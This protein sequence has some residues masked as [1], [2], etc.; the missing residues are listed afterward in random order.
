VPH[1]ERNLDRVS[2]THPARITTKEVMRRPLF[3]CKSEVKSAFLGYRLGH[4]RFPRQ[5]L[6][7]AER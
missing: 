6:H 5:H 1:R 3:S 4:R 7:L 2:E